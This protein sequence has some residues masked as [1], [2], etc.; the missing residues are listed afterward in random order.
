MKKLDPETKALIEMI[1]R[2]IAELRRLRAYWRAQL[3]AGRGRQ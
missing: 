3:K 1:D 2:R